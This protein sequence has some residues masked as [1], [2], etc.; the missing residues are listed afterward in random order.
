MMEPIYT[1]IAGPSRNACIWCGAQAS[2]NEPVL[3]F[4]TRFGLIRG[5]FFDPVTYAP[6]E[7]DSNALCP[8]N[9]HSILHEPTI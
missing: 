3:P 7:K 8:D 5:K 2:T 9:P 6:G 1:H 4:G